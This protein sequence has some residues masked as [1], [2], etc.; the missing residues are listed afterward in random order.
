V[1][2]RPTIDDQGPSE[3]A[4]SER[5]EARPTSSPLLGLR[6]RAVDFVRTHGE[7]DDDELLAHVYGARVP[8]A[9]RDRLLRPLLEDRRLRCD[10]SGRWSCALQPRDPH[11]P[12]PFVA[13][14]LAA[15]GP[16]PARH[17]LVALAALRV[18]HGQP[19]EQFAVVVHPEARIPKYVAA[20]LRLD[21]PEID[22]CPAFATVAD[23]LVA[24]LADSAIC[25]ME[26]GLAWSFLDAELRRLGTA[27]TPPLLIDLG[28]LAFADATLPGKPTLATIAERSGV[29]SVHLGRPT[30]DVRVVA[31]VAATL[32]QRVDDATL[33]RAVVEHLGEAPLRQTLAAHAAP[34]LPGVYTLRDADQRPVYIGKARRLRQRLTAYTSRPLAATRRLEGLAETVHSVDTDISESELE[35]LIL[36]QHEIER[37]QPRFNLQR[38]LHPWRTWIRLP[39]AIPEETLPRRRRRA[40]VRLE[41]CETHDTG[42]DA[43]CLGPF[44]TATGARGARDLVRVIFQLDDARQHAA[45]EDYA[46]VLDDAWR[47]LTGDTEP[48]IEMVR[49]RL[50]LAHGAR[51]FAAQRRW[52]RVLAAAHSYTLATLLLPAEPRHA[53][54]VVAR[55]GPGGV[56]V[57]LLDRGILVGRRTFVAGEPARFAAALLAELQPLTGPASVDLVVRWMV[58]QRSTARV[59]LVPDDKTGAMLAVHQALAAVLDASADGR[60]PASGGGEDVV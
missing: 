42:N 58:S 47:F 31:R 12:D 2:R 37:L 5:V 41:L 13:L 57:Y 15:T 8:P 10:T 3:D 35:A 17:R 32:F 14:A 50:A 49:R 38:Q 53:R 18:R 25:A 20:R 39:A 48:G 9:V 7:V 60:E 19:A 16:H 56:E 46:R 4:A 6:E 40:R 36:E 29:A 54:Y 33:R 51:D 52:Q 24:F 21:L 55:P 11:V 22:G 26:V 27:L 28:T 23:E 34:D 44:R 30:D 45:D 43:R 59:L 1:D